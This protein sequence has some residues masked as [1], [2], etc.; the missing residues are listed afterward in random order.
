MCQRHGRKYKISKND[1]LKLRVK[2]R[3]QRSTHKEEI[4]GFIIQGKVKG[5]E[6]AHH[7]T[8]ISSSTLE[9]VKY[10]KAN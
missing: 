9:S 6:R 8:R 4:V 2:K 1:S 7:L 5:I 3:N 10:K